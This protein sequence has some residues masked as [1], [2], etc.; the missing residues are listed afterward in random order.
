MI[1]QII[2]MLT[3]LLSYNLVLLILFLFGSSLIDF[4]L[5][6]KRTK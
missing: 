3:K 5:A 1:L 4:L 2:I 6:E